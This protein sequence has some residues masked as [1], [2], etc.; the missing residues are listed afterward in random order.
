MTNYFHMLHAGHIAY[1]ILKFKN[2]YWLS[3]HG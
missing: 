3:Q 1:Y 2:L